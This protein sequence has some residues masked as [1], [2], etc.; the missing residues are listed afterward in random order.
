MA[1]Q[2]TNS[3]LAR[4]NRLASILFR[5]ISRDLDTVIKVSDLAADTR[6]KLTQINED[7]GLVAGLLNDASVI[8]YSPPTERRYVV[9]IDAPAGW[10]KIEGPLPDAQDGLGLDYY[11]C[12]NFNGPYTAEEAIAALAQVRASFGGD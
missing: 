10:A 1:P 5:Q 6:L 11:G 12:G 9:V 8:I 4:L 3:E 7:A 2:N